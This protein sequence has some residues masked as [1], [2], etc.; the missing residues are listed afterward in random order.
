MAE[1]VTGEAV[2]LD[3]AVARFPSRLLA[4]LI[5]VAVQAPVV[6]FLEVVVFSR[7]ASHL[8][9]ASAAAID[10]I[11]AMFVIVGYPLTFETL[12]RGKTLGKMALGIRVVSDDGSPERFRQALIRALSAAFIEI[13]LLPINLIGL[14][15]GLIT[16]MVSAKGKRLGDVFA[17]TFVIQER[18]PRR[19]D[20]APVHTVIPPSLT[21]WAQHLELSRLS[22]Q[23]AAAASSYLRRYYDLRPAAREQLGL[24]LASAVAAQVSPPPPPGTDAAAFL[25]AVL[26]VRRQREQARLAARQANWQGAA[27]QPPA[28]PPGYLP[29]F[30]YPPRGTPAPQGS[31]APRGSLA[32]QGTPASAGPPAPQATPASQATP[33]PDGTPATQD[34]PAPGAA[35]KPP[36]TLPLGPDDLVPLS[37]SDQ[38]D[39]YGF[40]KPF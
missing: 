29:P 16:S 9:P 19:P 36:A 18:V 11:G 3:L 35:Q 27:G 1:V 8:N 22:D 10:I 23:T 37:K 7:S 26:A 15:A 14:P 40:A 31:L 21:G 4:L 39:D 34:A 17:G 20:L 24:Q 25:A 2:V 13:W 6:I 28:A 5:D 12:S 33:A 38:P 30:G 32:P